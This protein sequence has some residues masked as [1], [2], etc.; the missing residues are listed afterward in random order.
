MK[1]TGYDPSHPDADWSGFVAPRTSRKHPDGTPSAMA[2][3]ISLQG[4]NED[5]ETAEWAR[6]ARKVV[7]ST[8]S[9]A[10][11]TFSLIGGPVPSDD[12]SAFDPGQWETEAKASMERRKRGTDMS[13]LTDT[14][15]AKHIR[16]KKTD[17]PDCEKG[18]KEDEGHSS[19]DGDATRFLRNDGQDLTKLAGYRSTGASQSLL[20]GL[21]VDVAKNVKTTNCMAVSSSPYATDGNLPTDPYVAADGHRKKDLLLENYS[22]VIPGYTGKRTFI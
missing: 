1:Q 3:H 21:A 14:G 13:R 12:P 20:D 9:K 2:V 8:R 11:S 10:G 5:A 7:G 22:S 17:V 16:G 6:P 4:P 19:G 15:R 18:M